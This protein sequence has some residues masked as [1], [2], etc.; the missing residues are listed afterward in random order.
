MTINCPVDVYRG[1]H[2]QMLFQIDVGLKLCSKETPTQMFSCKCCEFLKSISFHR[3]PLIAASTF[4]TALSHDSSSGC[5]CSIS[6]TTSNLNLHEQ[7]V[8]VIIC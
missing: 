1:S 8:S 4:S 2:S 7:H 5:F 3:K 6:I